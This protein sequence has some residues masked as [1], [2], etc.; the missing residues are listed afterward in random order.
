MLLHNINNSNITYLDTKIKSFWDFNSASIL[1]IN[2]KQFNEED[3]KGKSF[4][5]W[6]S[7]TYYSLLSLL[8]IIQ[9]DLDHSQKDWS[10]YVTKYKLEDI[11]KCLHCLGI[12]LKKNLEN[13]QFPISNSNNTQNDTNLAESN[14]SSLEVSYA[15][16]TAPINTTLN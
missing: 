5:Q 12:D 3:L 4:L 9:L 13:W 7:M 2:T 6:K 14:S 1:A 15:I 8:M 11:S 16:E 10:Y